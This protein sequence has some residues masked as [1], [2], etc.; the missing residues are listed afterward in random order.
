MQLNV[1]QHMIAEVL[2]FIVQFVGVV[3]TVGLE[4]LNHA[5]VAGLVNASHQTGLLRELKLAN[6][7]GD[8]V[9]H[10][11]TPLSNY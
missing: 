5:I 4:L 7:H 10:L 2:G 11:G 3:G 1:G 9:G 6:R 8:V